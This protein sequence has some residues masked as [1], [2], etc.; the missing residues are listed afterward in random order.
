MRAGSSSIPQTTQ[1]VTRLQGTQQCP[2]L[3]LNAIGAWDHTAGPK[4]CTA[5]GPPGSQP[6]CPWWGT[7][8]LRLCQWVFFLPL[9]PAEPRTLVRKYPGELVFW[10]T[11]WSQPG[12]ESTGHLPELRAQECFRSWDMLDPAQAPPP[13]YLGL[14]HSVGDPQAVPGRTD[15]CCCFPRASSQCQGLALSW[16]GGSEGGWEG[17][18]GG[19]FHAP[20]SQAGGGSRAIWGKLGSLTLSSIF[21]WVEA[22]HVNKELRGWGKIFHMNRLYILPDCIF[23]MLLCSVCLLLS[24]QWRVW[25]KHSL[26]PGS[27]G[28]PAHTNFPIHSF[29]ISRGR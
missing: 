8:L 21:P 9:G 3:G 28:T 25:R 11:T 26:C 17:R 16:L 18:E 2:A 15:C 20:M 22:I 6:T 27:L 19:G 7:P 5:H 14:F 10:K 29:T 12:L 1:P 23:T 13:V 4:A 24:I